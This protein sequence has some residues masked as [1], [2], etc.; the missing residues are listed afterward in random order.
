M[1]QTRNPDNP[2]APSRNNEGNG[3]RVRTGIQ[4]PG[5]LPDWIVNTPI[6]SLIEP[7]GKRSA[8]ADKLRA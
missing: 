4:T 1:T 2:P 3:S 5:G 8:K 6:R 7:P